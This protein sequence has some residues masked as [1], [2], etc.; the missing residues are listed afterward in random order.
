M[1]TRGNQ[2]IAMNIVLDSAI[3]GVGF[4]QT[5]FSGISKYSKSVQNINLLK[6]TNFGLLKKNL[7]SLENHLGHIRGQSAKITANPIRLDIIS[8]RDSLKQA[9]KDMNAIAQD[10][11][12]ARNY[13]NLS[14]QDQLK[15]KSSLSTSKFSTTP[16]PQ[17]S[18]KKPLSSKEKRGYI[19]K[20]IKTVGGVATVGALGALRALEPIKESLNFETSMA[21]VQKATNTNKKQLKVLKKGIE[22]IIKVGLLNIEGSLLNVNEIASI[23]TMGGKSGVKQKALPRFTQ[24]IV[25]AS[26]AMDLTPSQS[27]TSFAK[28][29]ER[30]SL[31]I[32]KLNVLTNAFTRLESSG[33]NFAIDLIDTTGRLS[34]VFKDLNFK[35]KNSTAISN[36]MNTLEVSSELAASSFKIL[37]DRFKKTDQKL[38][39]YTKLKKGGAESLKP[40]IQDITKTMSTQQIIKNFGSQGMNVI[41][42]MKG[43]YKTLDKSLAVVGTSE[44][45]K[46]IHRAI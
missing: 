35:P 1:A 45:K 5:S 16:N 21:D 15:F 13:N 34:G 22:K 30:M 9:R 2:A 28:M 40:I 11:R 46:K 6:K 33:S 12:T 18:S 8:S 32:S 3:K 10:A 31:P 7:K 41:N 36:Y 43:N 25:L 39:Y 17:T 37:M 38:G 19:S 14:Y 24:D 29:S 26:V 20:K 23:Q 44:Q 42:N 27:A 4:L